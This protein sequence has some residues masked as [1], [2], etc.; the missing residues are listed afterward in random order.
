MSHTIPVCYCEGPYAIVTVCYCASLRNN[1]RPIG[2]L[3]FQTLSPT[4]E[5]WL[6][7]SGYNWKRLTSCVIASTPPVRHKHK[8]TQQYTEIYTQMGPLIPGYKSIISIP[9]F[10]S[11]EQ[12]VE[13]TKRILT[14]TRCRIYID[15]QI[16]TFRSS[17]CM[18][19]YTL[20]ANVCFEHL[21]II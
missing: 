1:P 20:S 15:K 13:L 8:K 5:S 14:H 9:L 19:R 7:N 12:D 2:N 18:H 6:R 10:F 17:W 4:T 21:S 3:W 11:T 16:N